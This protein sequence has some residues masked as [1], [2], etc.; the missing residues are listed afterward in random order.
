MDVKDMGTVNNK[1]IFNNNDGSTLNALPGGTV[2]NDNGGLITVKANALFFIDSNFNI[3]YTIVI[4][5]TTC[6]VVE[7]SSCMDSSVSITLT[8][9][10]SQKMKEL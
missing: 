10:R 7:G 8:L 2:N 1:G 4:K 6:F 9:A 3:S 5:S